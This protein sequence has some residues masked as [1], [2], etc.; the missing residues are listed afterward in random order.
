MSLSPAPLLHPC[1][2]AEQKAFYG[3]LPETLCDLDAISTP[4]E[5]GSGMTLMR[6][7]DA[8][9]IVRILC[10]GQA[11]ISTASPDGKTLLLSIV[12]AGAILGLVA[13]VRQIKYETT[14]EAYGPCLVNQIADHDFL[15]FIFR[16]RIASWQVMQMLAGENHDLLV[17]ARRVALSGTVAGNVAKLL[18]DWGTTVTAMDGK[19]HFNMVLTHQEIAE[20]VGTTRE[21]VTRTLASFR[22]HGWIRIHGASVEILQQEKMKGISI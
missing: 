12:G 1:C 9:H 22:Q 14:A 3:L 18:L 4:A 13:A 8:S 19:K 11:K 6:Q 7:G 10:D 2:R 15:D 5:Y 17:N 16:H 21:T 20:M